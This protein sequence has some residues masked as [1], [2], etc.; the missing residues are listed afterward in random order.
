MKHL[1]LS[2]E[3]TENIK[4]DREAGKS[5]REIALKFGISRTKVRSILGLVVRKMANGSTDAVKLKIK[6]N[7]DR[8]FLEKIKEVEV[9]EYAEIIRG[10]YVDIFEGIRQS[11]QDM[12]KLNAEQKD[13]LDNMIASL[14]E[15]RNKFDRIS[16]AEAEAD[17]DLRKALWKLISEV[18]SYYGRG[19]LRIDSRRELGSWI[20]R[21]KDFNMTALQFNYYGKII[22]SI[23]EGINLLGPLEYE[24][25]RNASIGVFNLT[26]KYFNQNEQ[27][28]QVS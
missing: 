23:F 16:D 15:V 20:D 21:Y 18:S 6:K 13:A 17:M 22:N 8:N 14:T 12:I 3:E 28:D 27:Q 24:K 7:K 5:E 9:K 25:V 26:E 4:R 10:E 2:E 11:M 19:K 1:I